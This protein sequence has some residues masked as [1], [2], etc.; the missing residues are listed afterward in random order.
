MKA[1]SEISGQSVNSV[2]EAGRPAKP[3]GSKHRRSARA[4][5]LAAALC[6]CAI[7]V[8]AQM[9]PPA[10]MTT[11]ALSAPSLPSGQ[12]VTLNV[13]V[14]PTVG[15]WSASGPDCP[16]GVVTVRDG[17]AV[18]ATTQATVNGKITLKLRLGL[19]SHSLTANFAG[20][21]LYAPSSSDP[22]PFTVTGTV[23][24]TTTISSAGNTGSYTLT[25]TVTNSG[26]SAPSGTV[27]F[28]DTTPNVNRIL[29]AAPLGSS[30]VTQSFSAGVPGSQYSG[31]ALPK[32]VAVAD[33]DGDGKP[34]LAV[35]Y[36]MGYTF[37]AKGYLCSPGAAGIL[38]GNGDGTFRA[39][40]FYAVG[41][42]SSSIA[43]G[44]LNGDGIPDL[45]VTNANFC[46]AAGAVSVLLGNGDGTFQAQQKYAVGES[47]IAIVIGDLN[48]D[49]VPDLAVAD[50]SFNG[51]RSDDTVSILLGNGDGTFRPLQSLPVGG[52]PSS[53]AVGD[54]NNDGKPDLAVSYSSGVSV[55]LGNGNGTFE[56]W[57]S[58]PVVGG[59]YSV[60]VGD[61]NGDGKPDLAVSNPSASIVSVLLGN[62]DGTFPQKA[63]YGV[64]SF[65]GFIVVN[66]F[67]AD[68]IPDLAVANSN[69]DGN[70]ISVLLGKGDGTFQSEVTYP[71][72]QGPM[73]LAAGDLDGDGLPDLVSAN[74]D[75]N[76]SLLFN[77][78]TQSA[79]AT[80]DNVAVYGG[81][82][83]GV[84]ASYAG[85][86]F[87]LPSTSSAISLQGTPIPTT[88][89]FGVQ[90]SAG[91][92]AGQPVQLSATVQ[93]SSAYNYI[94]SG[95]VTFYSNGV[96]LGSS[97]VAANSGTATL[98]TTALPA[99]TDA[100]TAVY[101]GDTNFA[102]SSAPTVLLSVLPGPSFTLTPSS[103]SEK[104]WRDRHGNWLGG[105]VLTLQSQN[106]F[107]GNVQLSCSGGP[108][109]TGCVDLPGTVRLH[110][111]AYALA[112]VSFPAKTP[113]GTY[114]VTFTGVAGSL[115]SSTTVNFTVK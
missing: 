5:V 69:F 31:G 55:L 61:F 47:P 49:G 88:L 8:W 83:H 72:G 28:T 62:G 90:P 2:S 32:G 89:T 24:T 99:G 7:S 110:G 3:P 91:V 96:S 29:G 48:G 54:L 51:G 58:F 22:Q 12:A 52:A 33:L 112:G 68:G 26:P 100:L 25:G 84:T 115:T 66:D 30:A 85:D 43:V 50:G 37:G 101:S 21:N 105:V 19:G 42:D 104:T 74:W 93:P 65:G 15:S 34:D 6:V 10:T 114:P 14:E 63:A 40:K 92:Q 81:G 17:K 87:H 41:L 94:A 79:I 23:A 64:D 82:T 102:G 106:G 9:T 27:T 73:F 35:V 80:L 95:F 20:T 59:A 11:L 103:S 16:R 4:I 98:I 44:D 36:S 1:R 109:G 97:P 76:V 60:A 56:P 53:I 13:T 18:V 78:V 38:L 67:N 71:A 111:T 77:H 113:S 108:A 86:A 46:G 107:Q 70:T 39:Q 57:Q 45:A 75:N